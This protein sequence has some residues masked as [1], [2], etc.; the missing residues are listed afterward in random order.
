MT[1]HAAAHRDVQTKQAHVL[2]TIIRT[3]EANTN[4]ALHKPAM[5]PKKPFY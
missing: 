4:S 1:M 5:I 2:P 3:K